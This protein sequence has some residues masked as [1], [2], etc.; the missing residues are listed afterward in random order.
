MGN[1][2]VNFDA[3]RELKNALY[4]WKGAQLPEPTS[5]PDK[6]ELKRV[7]NVRG[8]FFTTQPNET[9]TVINA[10]GAVPVANVQRHGF[11]LHVKEQP[12]QLR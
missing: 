7:F 12:I 9:D 11:P 3:R 6:S 10:L 8:F 5:G 4:S 2:C 1:R